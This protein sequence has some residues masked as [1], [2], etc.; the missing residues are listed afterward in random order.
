MIFVTSAPYGSK[1]LEL[2]EASFNRHCRKHTLLMY[3]NAAT[4]LD[5]YD[6]DKLP[7]VLKVRSMAE[8]ARNTITEKNN[9]RWE[10]SR[11]FYK[12]V[13]LRE[14]F[15]FCST[16][17]VPIIWLD[18]DVE[19][20]KPLDVKFLDWLNV[21]DD[22]DFMYLGR[23][24][25]H[26]LEAGFM[27]FNHGVGNVKEFLTRVLNCYLTGEIFSLPEW[28]DSYIFDYIRKQMESEGRLRTRNLSEGVSGLHVWP[29][30]IL[31]EY[32][33]HHKGPVRKQE[34]YGAST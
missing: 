31:G 34:R 3:C 27:L 2:L 6:L 23:K 30:T 26:H 32:M 5:E 22:V 21:N 11:F 33:V 10:V 28:H 18:S 16:L 19:I 20:L 24:D 8:H 4:D 15:L 29:K 13:A 9:Y 17:T 1:Q 14:A 7:E 25:W 12:I